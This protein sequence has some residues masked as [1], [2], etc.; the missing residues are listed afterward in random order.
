M[1]L[2]EAGCKVI[3]VCDGLVRNH[4]K[5]ASIK[6]R[7]DKEILKVKAISARTTI[8]SHSQKNHI[9]SDASEKIR[10]EK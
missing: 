2:K 8:V 7:F 5:R 6:R 9:V 3:P 1:V 4:T 10:L